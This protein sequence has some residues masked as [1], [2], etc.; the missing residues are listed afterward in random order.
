MTAQQGRAPARGR[1]GPSK[2]DQREAAILE[3]ARQLLAEQPL[4]AITVDQLAKGA[5]LSRSTFYFYFD[6]RDTVV[7]TLVADSLAELGE[8]MNDLTPP[9]PEA[10]H[11]AIARYLDRWRH[12]GPLLRAF[13][14]TERDERVETAWAEAHTRIRTRL[15]ALIDAERAA[16]RAPSGP[17]APLL[18]DALMAMMWR[19]GYEHSLAPDTDPTAKVDTLT[20]VFTR[21]IW[22][23]P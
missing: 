11:R 10:F 16:G 6:S 20:A 15:S 13:G 19:A 9:L 14:S 22:C 5:G 4:S 18:A 3:T 8:L 12:H 2:G 23:T 21:T 7:Y 17:P 1:R